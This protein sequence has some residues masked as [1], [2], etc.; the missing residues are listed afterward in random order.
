MMLITARRIKERGYNYRMYR[1]SVLRVLNFRVVIVR[2][3]K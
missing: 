1:I 3:V 2:F